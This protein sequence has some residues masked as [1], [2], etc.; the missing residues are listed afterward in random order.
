M[1]PLTQAKRVDPAHQIA[2]RLE[3]AHD[4]KANGA[5]YSSDIAGNPARPFCRALSLPNFNLSSTA[6]CCGSKNANVPEA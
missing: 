1:M 2:A 3:Y 5:I 6:R 4:L